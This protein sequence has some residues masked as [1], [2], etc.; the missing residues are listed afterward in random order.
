MFFQNHNKKGIDM[1]FFINSRYKK[2]EWGKD[3]KKKA[4]ILSFQNINLESNL[5]IN[6]NSC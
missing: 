4:R 2:S 6:E 3:E 1:P 5:R